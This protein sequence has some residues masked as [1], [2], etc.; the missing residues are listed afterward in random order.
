MEPSGQSEYDHLGIDW[1]GRPER[2]GV[3]R[4]DGDVLVLV[5]GVANDARLD[6]AACFDAAQHRAVVSIEDQKISRQF[7][8]EHKPSGGRRDRR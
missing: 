8:G 4:H 5:D 6:R 3:A 7:S 1:V 2:R